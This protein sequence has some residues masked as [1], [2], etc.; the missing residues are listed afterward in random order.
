MEKYK[1]LFGR[2]ERCDQNRDRKAFPKK[3][4][5]RTT[6]SNVDGIRKER[7]RKISTKTSTFEALHY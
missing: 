1:R 3:E 5:N 6:C 7:E 4:N 2:K